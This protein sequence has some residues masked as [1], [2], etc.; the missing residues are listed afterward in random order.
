MGWYL[1]KLAVTALVVVAVSEISKRSTVA[2][3]LLAS[4]PL[5]SV[6]A[7]IWIWMET[8]DTAR[9]AALSIDILWLVPPSLVLFLL[10]PLLLRAGMA[11]WP[12]LALGILATAAAWL[13]VLR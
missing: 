11:F 12:A 7:M 2:G 8:R 1:T 3:A 9:I 4:L 13:A 5:V 10:L 6:L